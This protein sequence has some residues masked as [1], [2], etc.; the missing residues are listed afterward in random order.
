MASW[1]ALVHPL[2]VL[3]GVDSITKQLEIRDL[4][5]AD[6]STQ[7]ALDLTALGDNWNESQR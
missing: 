2:T 5:A 7:V 4:M 3:G 1:A 6:R